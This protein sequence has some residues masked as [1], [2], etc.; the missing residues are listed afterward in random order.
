[1][2][3]EPD[4][5]L[6][7]DARPATDAT[8]RLTGL[9]TRA[10]FIGRLQQLLAEGGV[11]D[12]DI[13]AIVINLNDFRSVNTLYG[14]ATGDQVLRVTAERLLSGTRSRGLPE[15]LAAEGRGDLVARLGADEFAILGGPPAPPVAEAEALAARLLRAVENPMQVDGNSLRLAAR[16]GVVATAAGHRSPDDLL[17]ALD[18][19]AQRANALGP[20]TV[21]V[22]Q[23]S[24]T[25][26]AI[27]RS[28]LA[29]RLRRA[30]DNGEFVLHYQPVLRLSDSRLVGAEGLLRWNDPSEGLRNCASFVPVLEESGLIV[31]LGNWVLRE[32]VRQVEMWD[33]LY[34][35]DVVDWVGVNLSGLQLRHP[36]QLLATLRAIDAGGFSLRRLKLEISAAAFTRDPDDADGILGELRALGVR[37]AIDDFGTGHVGPDSL[38]RHPVEAIKIDREFIAGIGTAPGERLLQAL[39]AIARLYDAAIIA[40]G[41]ETPAQRDFLR[42]IGCGFGQGYLFAEPM[43][44]ALFGTYALTH[45]VETGSGARLAG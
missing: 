31:E 3:A 21:V 6:A 34:G 41:I 28:T 14:A 4:I 1:M 25:A 15:A 10:A 43:D 27:R 17:R 8:D 30:F 22:W 38:R 44:A 35:R 20:G 18:L 11:P 9:A 23:P 45:A 42:Q 26:A 13:L 39:F 24:L 36:E 40:E 12:R 5:S 2:T 32:T 29:M 16:A 7:G 37:I 33:A 19:A